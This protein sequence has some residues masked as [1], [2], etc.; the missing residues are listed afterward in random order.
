[1]PVARHVR[2]KT[3]TLV[4]KSCLSGLVGDGSDVMA[5][6]IMVQGFKSRRAL[7]AVRGAQVAAVNMMMRYVQERDGAKVDAPATFDEPAGTDYETGG[8]AETE[9][10]MPEAAGALVPEARRLA[11][12]DERS[13]SAVSRKLARAPEAGIRKTPPPPPAL[14]PEEAAP[15]VDAPARESDL[16]RLLAGPTSV[17]MGLGGAGSLAGGEAVPGAGLF[18]DFGRPLVG[19]EAAIYGTDYHSVQ[20]PG[21]G[22]SEWTRMVGAAGPRYRIKTRAVSVDL[23]AALAA[24]WIWV[25]GHG[26]QQ[27]SHSRMWAFGAGLGA[28]LSLERSRLAPWIGVDAMAWPGSHRIAVFD[29]AD[30]KAIPAVD[31]LMSL[32]FSLKLF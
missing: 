26:F 16:S 2:A 23:K 3:G 14:N 12:E 15:A 8:E 13:R 24:G 11:L 22:R 28:R 17:R 32:G 9:D 20:G 21:P 1:L 18:V 7:I 10:E 31:L 30:T 5:F 6:S 27:D 29:V 19:I 4:G 25:H